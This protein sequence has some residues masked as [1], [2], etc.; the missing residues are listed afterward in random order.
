MDTAQFEQGAARARKTSDQTAGY[1]RTRFG[2]V[3]A[4]IKSSVSGLIAGLTAGTILAAGK[5]ALEY[6]G[7]LGELADTLGLTT[8]DLQTFSYAAGQV[9]I[10]QEELESGIQKLT[11]SMGKAQVGSQAQ[12]KAFNAI[13]ISI[14][15]LRG[16]D[17]G[18]VFRMI[19]D[20]LQNVTDRSQRAAVEVALFGKAGAKLDNLLS[21]S[22]GRLSDLADA[23]ERLGLVLSDEQIQKADET[24]DKLEAIKTVLKAQIAGVIADNAQAILDLAS[25]FSALVG[26]IAPVAFELRRAGVEMAAFI[27]AG[28]K[29]QNPFKAANDASRVLDFHA[30]LDSNVAGITRK[31]PRPGGVNIGDFLAGAGPKPKK[32][33]S[34][35]EL[36]RKQLD[37]LRKSYDFTQDELRAQED[38]LQAKKDLS[39]DYVEQTTLQ[40]Q[41]LDNQRAQFQAD[42]DYQVKQNEITKGAD[43]ISKAQ[44]D[45]KQA[46][47]DQADSLKRQKVLEDEQESRL[48]DIALLEDHD[49]DRKRETLEK[50]SDIATTQAER[51]QIELELLKLAYE[52]KRQALQRIIDQSKDDA[53]IEDARR[54]LLTLNKNYALD[55]QG[56]MQQT[57][58]PLENYLSNIPH[59]AAQVNEALQ[60]IEVQGLQGLVDALSHVGEGWKAMRD[61]A[62]SA[63]QDILAQLIKLQ[64]E[65]MLFSV[66][67]SAA[68]GGGGFGGLVSGNMAALGASSGIALGASGGG[69][70]PGF[71][72]GGAFNVIGHRGTDRN[73]LSLNGLPI[74]RVSHGERVSVGHDAMRDGGGSV[75]NFHINGNVS[76]E[77]M[78]QIAARTQ[79]AIASAKRRGY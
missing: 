65:K 58:G 53:A 57:Q 74:A 52:E 6:A 36:Q 75:I 27:Q 77:T 42:L 24:A 54:D 28:A 30:R 17:A 5:A 29:L 38:I 40:I 47:Y 73:V 45:Q 44:A 14:D 62:L 50:M 72:T 43:G 37:A 26:A 16:K 39:S 19:A 1:I 64:L 11:I 10:S 71:A 7:H 41:I 21:G 13:G 56:V 2:S 3:G 34:A 31:A 46:L 35:E 49:L 78:G 33:H 59:T 25:A 61:I 23:A 15:Q 9:G 20:K 69:S 63:I 51:R 66:I 32:D 60:G 4:S 76:R 79:N 55:R 48:R 8:K 18:E 22:Q 70:L 67:G 12:I 68:G